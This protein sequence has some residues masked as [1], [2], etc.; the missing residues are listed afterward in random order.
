M[1]WVMCM[2]KSKFRTKYQKMEGK[3]ARRLKF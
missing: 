3:K 1:R 2:V